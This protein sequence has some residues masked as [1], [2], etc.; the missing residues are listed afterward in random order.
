MLIRTLFLCLSSAA[1]VGCGLMSGTPA[2]TPYPDGHIPTVVYLTAVAIDAAKQTANPPTLTPTVTS[3]FIP[4]TLAPTRSPTP[5]PRVPSAA[6]QVRAPGPM[7]RV[8]SPLQLQLLAIA[9]DSRRIE[10]GLF[11]EDGRLLGRSLIAV[12]GSALGD[13]VSVKLP[14]EIRAVGESGFVQ[15]S[16][17][18]VRGR[19]QALI[20]VPVILL[21]SGE[22]QINPAGNTIYERVALTGLEAES[23]VSGGLLEVSGEVLPYN[24]SP[25]IMELITDEGTAL[26]LRVLIVPGTDW[27]GVET[28]LPY[29][30]EKATP[31]RLFVR[32][33]DDLL[34]GDGY[35]FSL[36]LNL[37]P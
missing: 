22:S 1:L 8:V 3:T 14:F 23:D 36:P 32:Q 26:S 9:G 37:M 20:T 5:G 28:T 31:A 29:R 19:I 34:G 10:I 24:R 30:V 2:P 25:V 27:Q 21:S 13:S 7:S 11:G 35:V 15:V 18:D 4:P 16:T 33:S 17:R 12:P 6:I